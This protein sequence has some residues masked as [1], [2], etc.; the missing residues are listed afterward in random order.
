MYVAKQAQQGVEVYSRD[1][2]DNDVRGL[3]LVTELRRDLD[4][5]ALAIPFQP[6]V[7]LS[8]GVVH[9][10]ESLMRWT[11]ASYGSVA[12]DQVNPITATQHLTNHPPKRA[13]PTHLYT[14]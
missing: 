13:L 11:S 2:D 12:P 6:L 4:E 1:R 5:D 14:A 10:V 7:A 9:G 3:A 8:P